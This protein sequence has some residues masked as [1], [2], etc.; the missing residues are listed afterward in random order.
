MLQALH[1]AERQ[2]LSMGALGRH[3]G[4][5]RSAVAGVLKRVRDDLERSNADG[6]FAV[7]PENRECGMPDL[8]WMAGLAA[9]AR[10]A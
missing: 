2:G 3:F 5:T 9:R 1:L 7:K 8:W 10:S 6:P 4:V